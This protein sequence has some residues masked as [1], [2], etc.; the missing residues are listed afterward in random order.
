MTRVAEVDGARGGCDRPFGGPSMPPCVTFLH[1]RTA[2]VHLDPGAVPQWSFYQ[3]PGPHALV[4]ERRMPITRYARSGDVNIAYQVAGDGPRDVV[5]VPGW[6]SNVEVMWEDPGLARF[7]SRIASF[8]RLIVFDKRG[9]GLSDPVPAEHLPSLEVRMDDLRA[10]MD[11]AGSTS[12]T[13]FGHSEGGV[14][15]VL[16]A[17]TYPDRTDGLILTG[18]PVKRLRSEDYPW[19][20]T[21]EE[22]VAES[23]SIERTWGD[24][25]GIDEHY[26]PSRAGDE[27]FRNWIS[28][29]LRL[30]ASPKAAARLHMMNTTMDVSTL[31]P[32]IR[33]PTLLL[34]RVD[35]PDVNVE[36]GR[37]IAA[38]IPDAKLV[39]LPGAD[40]F[41]WA[42]DAEPLLQ[43]IE[44][45]VTGHR[46]AAEPDRVVATAVFTDIVDSTD[47]AASL[48]DRAWRDL[49]QRH[50]HAIR[51]ELV[52]W[53]GDEVK[54]TGDGFLATFD[55]PA[56]A[57]RC[58]QAISRAIRP[59]GIEVRCGL[60]TGEMEILQGDVAGLGVHI[61]ARVLALAS[62]SEVLVSRTVK[63]L[64]AGSGVAF[65]GRGPHAL[66]GVPDEWEI[67]AAV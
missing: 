48:G 31:L 34:Y 47:L 52:K 43:E 37:Y 10:V 24:P 18:S 21:W 7:L 49:L 30:S 56:R 46:T 12:A 16:F 59:L 27:A 29:Y 28:R 66:K 14:L 32:A 39:E 4:W 54:T 15:C 36:E 63:D 42:G 50:D 1:R 19:A 2:S 23:E 33:V 11:A 41:F 64:V 61:A 25:Q 58:A 65:E 55:G 8:S 6:V 5:Y 62:P 13:L 45:F 38:R 60:H 35:D 53:R 9:T 26:A 44:E 20:P 3:F 40:H 17:G 22:R 57:I 51:G 67:Y